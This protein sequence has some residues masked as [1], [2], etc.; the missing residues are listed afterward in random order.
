MGETDS[1]KE[2]RGGTMKNANE[3]YNLGNETRGLAHEYGNRNLQ[4]YDTLSSNIQ[5]GLNDPA[6]WG[7]YGGGGGGGGAYIAPESETKAFYR[8]RMAG[9]GEDF[10]TM[11]YGLGGKFKEATGQ[12]GLLGQAGYQDMMNQNA[13]TTAANYSGMRRGLEQSGALS[14]AVGPGFTEQNLAL[15]TQGARANVGQSR[16]ARIALADKIA[17][18]QMWGAEQGAQGSEKAQGFMGQGA[19]GLHGLEQE[20]NANRERAAAASYAGQQNYYAQKMGLLNAGMNLRG[21]AGSELDYYKVAGGM[22]GGSGQ[23]Y[24][25][26]PDEYMTLDRRLDQAQQMA[27]IYG[28]V[29]N[30]TANLMKAGGSGSGKD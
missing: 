17:A 14:G 4:L 13:A 8:N 22:Y 29:A 30:P 24:S 9:K 19:S 11:R 2:Q 10:D 12:Y 28:S 27:S 3:M 1:S 7:M 6:S 20:E 23:L 21:Q 5:A 26:M 16:D 18:Q 25:G 15:A